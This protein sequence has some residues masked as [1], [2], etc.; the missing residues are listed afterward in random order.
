MSSNAH[1]IALRLLSGGMSRKKIADE[2][3][4]SRTAISLFLSGRYGAGT[5]RLERAILRHFDRFPC[6]HLKSDITRI[7][8]AS[9]AMC[10]CPTSNTRDVRHW[11]ACQS[12]P[13]KPNPQEET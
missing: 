7:Y 2:I 10:P 12:C 6:P 13:H 8:C 3:S 9:H 1:E 5:A 4:Y 11:R